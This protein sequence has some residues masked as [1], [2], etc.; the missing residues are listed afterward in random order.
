MYLVST[1]VIRHTAMFYILL[2]AVCPGAEL[3]TLLKKGRKIDHG[4]HYPNLLKQCGSRTAWK[5]A[6][7]HL[8]MKLNLENELSL[9]PHRQCLCPTTGVLNKKDMQVFA[10][11]RTGL[12]YPSLI[13]SILFLHTKQNFVVISDSFSIYQQI[14]NRPCMLF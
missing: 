13:K 11:V 9:N 2:S 4:L 5:T 1:Q 3:K 7:E 8:V 14:N 10:D 6:G 12:F